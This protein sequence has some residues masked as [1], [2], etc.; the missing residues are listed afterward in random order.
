MD[1]GPK[2]AEG[3]KPLVQRLHRPPQRAVR[4]HFERL[5]IPGVSSSA[6]SKH[7]AERAKPADELAATRRG[8]C[9]RILI[10]RRLSI[11]RRPDV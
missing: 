1:L 6:T 3:P 5:E 7:P 8:R 9:S 10:V 4:P 11:F 2:H